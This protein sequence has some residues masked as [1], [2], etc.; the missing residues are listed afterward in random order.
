L[1]EVGYFK[2]LIK[3]TNKDEDANYKAQRA[4]RHEIILK[5]IRDAY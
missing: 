4:S 2:G 3:V 1:K 5:M